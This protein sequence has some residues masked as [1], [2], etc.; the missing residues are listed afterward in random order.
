MSVITDEICQDNMWDIR[1]QKEEEYIS[2]REGEVV[3]KKKKKE[4]KWSPSETV[5][6]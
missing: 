4:I 1:R 6:T 3:C 5:L 2:R